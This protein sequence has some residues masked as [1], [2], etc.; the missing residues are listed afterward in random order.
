MKKI[1]ASIMLAVGLLPFWVGSGGAAVRVPESAENLLC[2]AK[3]SSNFSSYEKGLR[4]EPD[5]MIYD[6]QRGRFVKRSQHH[7]YGVGFGENLG[8]VAESKPAWWIAEWGKPV[9]ANLI[10]LSGVY[11]NQPQPQTGW[12]IELRVGG[13]WAVHARGVGGWYDRG[14]YVWG[15]PGTES[16]VFDAIRVSLFS[17]DDRTSVKS[18]HLRGE[19]GVS[20]IVAEC[21]PIDVDLHLPAVPVR[22]GEGM[23]MEAVALAGDITRWQWDFGDGKKATG[24]TIRHTYEKP[25]AY[26]VTLTFGDAEHEGSVRGTVRVAP[27]VEARIRPLEGAVM[28]GEAVTLSGEGSIGGI[29]EYKWHFGDGASKNGLA[30]R[31]SFERAGIYKVRLVVGDGEYEDECMSIV[32][33]HTEETLRVPQVVLDTDQKNEQDDQHYLGY[34]LFSE[35]DILGVNSIHHGGGQEAVNYAEIMHIIELAKQS[36]LSQDRVPFVFRGA[37]KRLEVPR[38]GKWFDTAPVVSEASEAI[39]AAARGASPENPIWVVPVG[40]GT[41]TASAILQARAEGIELKDRMRVMW[42]GGSNDAIINEFNG[43]NDPWS[44]YVVAQSGIETWIMPAPVGARVRIDKRTEPQY[45]AENPLGRYLLKIVPAHNKPLFDPS[46][47]SAIISERLGLGWVKE[48][49]PVTVAG[50]E[51]GYRWSQTDE[52]SSV[53]VIRQIDQQAM[54]EDIFGTMKGKKQSLV[55]TA[56]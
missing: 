38:S 14:R 26:E 54:K 13:K 11:P 40:P 52:P 22:A 7:E 5:H 37:N 33:V 47:L 16:V 4:G 44:M 17:K 31:H 6:N 49:E 53:R 46:C 29:A 34:G 50:P 12:K 55:G 48:S 32:R 42:L 36:G 8:I 27:P 3:I 35:L 1:C 43:N 15:G 2:E 21:L 51:Q 45:Y 19:E 10:A 23:R 18:I 56:R 25:G 41:N 9:R 30:V 28:V 24:K 20:W 39:L